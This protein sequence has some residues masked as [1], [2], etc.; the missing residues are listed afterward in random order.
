MKNLVLFIIL[1]GCLL[2]AS[3]KKET[4]SENFKLLTE[5]YWFSDSLLVNGADASG[6]GGLLSKFK[7]EARFNTDY[8]GT[9]GVYSGTWRFAA[10]ETQL[11]I[12]TDS[13]PL[14]LTTNIV[15]LTTLSLKVTTSFPVIGSD[16]INIRMTFKA[17]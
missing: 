3:C 11:V 8:T 6:P 15:E 7:G 9:F 5:P 10:N 17:K 16:P 2:A 1:A 14:P 12:T 13:L 4:K